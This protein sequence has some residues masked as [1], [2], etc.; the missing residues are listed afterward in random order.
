MEGH[1]AETRVREATAYQE[2]ANQ[3]MEKF[4]GVR[5]MATKWYVSLP[6]A[7]ALG[8]I[9]GYFVFF[10]GWPGKPKIGV[11]DIPFTV[12]TDD[13]AFV[14]GAFLDYARE[15]DEIKAVV[16]RLNSPGGGAAASE[17][18]FVQTRKVREKKPVVII[19]N[20]IV[21]SGAYMMSLGANHTY[22]KPTSLVGS[23]GVILTSPG[24]LIPQ[25]PNERVASTGPF[26]LGGGT[27]RQFLT[28]MD[29]AKD[30]FAEMVVVERGDRL[31]ISREEVTQGRI[32]AGIEGVR[33]GL[34]D[35][36]GGDT[37]ALEMAASLAGI[38]NFGLVDINTEVFRILNEKLWRIVEPL[39]PLLGGE[40]QPGSG[41]LQTLLE[42]PRA[43]EDSIVSLDR[44]DILGLL[45]GYHLPTGIDEIQRVAPP[46]VPFELNTPRIYYLYVGP[47][48]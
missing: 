28:L 1:C 37:E 29:Q 43:T 17:Q 15:E 21:A 47:S 40:G 8:T 19:M 9:L 41:R 3:V 6:I 18:L 32:Y 33:L 24:P 25:T 22:A 16:I 4:S 30:A 14:I 45:R 11:I 44:L 20:D 26:K 46:G 36:I 42:P 12:I 39:E 10:E 48:G 7:V 23:V 2:P 31:R 5:T 27:R 13:S 34:V 35:D 38:S